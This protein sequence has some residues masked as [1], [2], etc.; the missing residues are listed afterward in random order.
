MLTA[1]ANVRSEEKATSLASGRPDKHLRD[2]QRALDLGA[3]LR[4]P[5]CRSGVRQGG[6]LVAACQV[7]HAGKAA[8][9]SRSAVAKA[10]SSAAASVMSTCA[11]VTRLPGSSAR[12][13]AG[14]VLAPVPDQQ[15]QVELLGQVANQGTPDAAESAGDQPA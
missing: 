2:R 14:H 3:G 11:Y 8:S 1:G 5:A 13:S 4:P 12:C 15:G 9:H 6:E 10:D 7:Q